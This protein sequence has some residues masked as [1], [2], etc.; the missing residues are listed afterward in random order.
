MH[1]EQVLADVPKAERCTCGEQP[2][3]AQAPPPKKGWFG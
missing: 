2:L 3:A 1:V